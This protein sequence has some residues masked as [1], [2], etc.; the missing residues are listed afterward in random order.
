MTN[1]T[2]ISI[3]DV[4][5]GDTIALHETGDYRTVGTALTRVCVIPKPQRSITLIFTDGTTTDLPAHTP[6]Y[7]INQPQTAPQLAPVQHQQTNQS[8]TT[9]RKRL[10]DRERTTKA[11]ETIMELLATADPNTWD[12]KH[13]IDTD[14]GPLRL[15][16]LTKHSFTLFPQDHSYYTPAGNLAELN[17]VLCHYSHHEPEPVDIHDLH[18]KLILVYRRQ[19]RANRARRTT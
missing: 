1:P 3:E 2:L 11:L 8:G 6:V 12:F 17:G 18:H 16:S 19:R 5:E 10:T 15:S 14:E 9:K 7:R 4:N 13:L